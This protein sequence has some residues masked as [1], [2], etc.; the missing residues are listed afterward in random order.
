MNIS[1]NTANGSS[2]LSKQNEADAVGA[3]ANACAAHALTLNC[4]E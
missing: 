4:G 1:C 3:E 2:G